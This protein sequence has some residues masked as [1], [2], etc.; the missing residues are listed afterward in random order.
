MKYLKQ[1]T[2][3]LTSISWM[4]NLKVQFAHELINYRYGLK[5]KLI[6]DILC[7]KPSPEQLTLRIKYLEANSLYLPA[8]KIVQKLVALIVK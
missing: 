4:S 3:I 2:L 5:T 6:L 7:T 1:Q 8:N